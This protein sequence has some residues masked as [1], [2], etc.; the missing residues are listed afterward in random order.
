M[1]QLKR[2]TML[3]GFIPTFIIGG[4]LWIFTGKDPII[5]VEKLIAWGTK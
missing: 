5:L 3:L 1:K 4:I 2:L